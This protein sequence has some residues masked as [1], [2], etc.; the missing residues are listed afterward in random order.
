MG[1]TQGPKESTPDEDNG[2][3]CELIQKGSSL[4]VYLIMTTGNKAVV[5]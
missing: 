1:S 2:V 3:S 4:E 5:E